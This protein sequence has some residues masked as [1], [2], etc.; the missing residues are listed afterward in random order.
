MYRISRSDVWAFACISFY[1]LAGRLPFKEPT[2]YLIF[3]KI[4]KGEY[5][6]PEGFDP[7]EQDLVEKLLVSPSLPNPTLVVHFIGVFSIR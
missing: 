4:Q 5:T 2:D 3:Q 1:F 7:T 6:F